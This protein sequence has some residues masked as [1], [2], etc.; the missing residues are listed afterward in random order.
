[1]TQTYCCN[2]HNDRNILDNDWDN[3]SS[4]N[5]KEE[6]EKLIVRRVSSFHIDVE[7]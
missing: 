1:M 6:D 4:N 3:K 7:N 2:D 5:D